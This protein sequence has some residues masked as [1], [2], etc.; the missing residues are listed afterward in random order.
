MGC[1]VWG[2]G[3]GV[4]GVWGVGCGVWGGGRGVRGAGWGVRVGGVGWCGVWGVGEVWASP[5]L[6]YQL[7]LPPHPSQF[8]PIS[9]ISGP[10]ELK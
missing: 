4:W 5:A 2:V 1:G 3:C 9:I 8:S 10:E 6:S 7:H